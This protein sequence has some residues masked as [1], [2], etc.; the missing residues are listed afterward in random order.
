MHFV[1][2]APFSVAYPAIAWLCWLPN[3]L[4]VEVY[5]RLDPT[6]SREVLESRSGAP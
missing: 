2:H 6:T 3:A 5:L 4:A 1:F